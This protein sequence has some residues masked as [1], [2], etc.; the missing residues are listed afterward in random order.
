ME[1]TRE[2]PG[3]GHGPVQLSEAPQIQYTVVERH[4]GCNS[5]AQSQC[6]NEALKESL[7]GEHHPLYD[8]HDE[9]GCK[10]TGDE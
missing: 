3:H 10:H 6:G 7:R 8:A 5:P 2:N 9:H 4:Y 1:D